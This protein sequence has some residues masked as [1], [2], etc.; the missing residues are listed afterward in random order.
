M[1]RPFSIRSWPPILIIG[2]ALSF[3]PAAH[4]SWQSRVLL[5]GVDGGEAI[6]RHNPPFVDLT[7]A[8]AGELKES[9]YIIFTE[10]TDKPFKTKNRNPRGLRQTIAA[11]EK[12]PHDR[13]DFAVLITAKREVGRR[14]DHTQ[15]SLKIIARLIDPQNGDVLETIKVRSQTQHIP[16]KRC[17][18]PCVKRATYSAGETIVPFLAL[19][20]TEEIEERE[21]DM[22]ADYDNHDDFYEYDEVDDLDLRRDLNG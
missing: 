1:F 5:I 16:K 18:A 13:V 12:L 7:D 22:R 10:N 3:A 20:L 2:L 9:T 19:R 11:V 4:A 8:L 17:G 21:D 14:A 6:P 15:F